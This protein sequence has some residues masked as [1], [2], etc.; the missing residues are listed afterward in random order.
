MVR[1]GE[2]RDQHVD[3]I[4]K[5]VFI[6]ASDVVKNVGTPTGANYAPA[7]LSVGWSFGS[8]TYSPIGGG[9]IGGIRIAATSTQVDYLW[10]LPSDVDKRHA[11]YFR[12]HWV[13]AIG[14]TTPTVSFNQ[15]YA[16]IS[17][18]TSLLVMSPIQ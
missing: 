12:H 13:P 1:Y 11:V 9:H 14:G 17:A 10:R 6:P 16:T 4:L 5:K 15:W 2:V 8:P 3:Y 18:G 7:T